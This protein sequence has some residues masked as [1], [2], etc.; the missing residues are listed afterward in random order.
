MMAATSPTAGTGAGSRD[1]ASVIRQVS[2][3][4]VLYHSLREARNRAREVAWAAEFR[5]AV[6]RRDGTL[7]ADPRVIRA[8][9]RELWVHGEYERLARLGE[10]LPA[11]VREEGATIL[12]Y[13]TCAEDSLRAGPATS[14]TA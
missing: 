12:M 11:N 6:G 1:I 10:R 9:Q 13:L 7:P 8:G 4:R 2:E 14:K 3:L 5:D